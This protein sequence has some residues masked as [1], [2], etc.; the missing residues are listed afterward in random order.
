M[1]INKS[2]NQFKR[3]KILFT[4]STRP[5]DL[6]KLPDGDSDEFPVGPE[7]HRSDSVFERDTM[8][9]STTAEVDEEAAIIFVDGEKEGVGVTA[10]RECW[11]RIE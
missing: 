3:K 8:E 9:K 4:K 6:N 7:F 1:K 2:T 5:P 11:R 10:M